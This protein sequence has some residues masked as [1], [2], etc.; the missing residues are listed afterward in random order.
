MDER[1]TRLESLFD[2]HAAAVAAYAL[3]RTDRDTAQ[4]VLSET[5][6]VAW[7]RLD[8][9]PAEPRPWLYAVARR[10]LANQRRSA[11]RWQSLR[12]RL[13]REAPEQLAPRLLDAELKSALRQ[14]SPADRELLLLVA[15]EGLS[16][17]EAA[18]VLGCAPS[19]A[20]LR[21]HRARRRLAAALGGASID[22]RVIEEVS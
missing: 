16:P 20:R 1:R 12:R 18:V 19:T 17:A 2:A 9:V 15:W 4:D 7:R 22:D 14:L 6:L 3:R 21:L 8:E 5:F 13:E 11:S 10:C